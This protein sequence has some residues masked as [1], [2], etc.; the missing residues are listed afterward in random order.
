MWDGL[1]RTISASTMYVRTGAHRLSTPGSTVYLCTYRQRTYEFQ[2]VFFIQRK[3]IE[4]V[5]PSMKKH[6]NLRS[7]WCWRDVSDGSSYDHLPAHHRSEWATPTLTSEIKKLSLTGTVHLL[8]LKAVRCLRKERE[9]T[10]QSLIV[11]WLWVSTRLL[12]TVNSTRLS[13]V[14]LRAYYN[15]QHCGNKIRYG[16]NYL[17]ET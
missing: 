17:W 5:T 1:Y 11:W 16:C 7:M 2:T 13:T 10:M 3:K 15:R 12:M 14:R 4:S 8:A 9:K 6:E